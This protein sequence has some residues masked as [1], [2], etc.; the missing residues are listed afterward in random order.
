INV[1][2]DD[3]FGGRGTGDGQVGEGAG[4]VAFN[5][6]F[7]GNTIHICPVGA[8]SGEQYRFRARPFDLV[9]TPTA[10]EHCASGCSLR[11]DHRRGKVMRRLAGDDGAVNEEW[12]CDKSR[13]PFTSAS[14]AARLTTPLIRNDQTGQLE[15]ASWNDAL[16]YAAWGLAQTRDR[17]GVGVLA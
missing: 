9:S 15:P 5:S 3:F 16:E 13:F 8:R 10:C 2:R 11:T 6:Y 4:D 17:D 12:S 7:S 14:Q 1:Y